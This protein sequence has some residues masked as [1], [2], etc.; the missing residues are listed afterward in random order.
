M[1]IG[2]ALALRLV[3]F[4]ATLA[5][6][7][8][9]LR[10][11]AT[12]RPLVQRH[13]WRPFVSGALLLAAWTA[14]S[15]LESGFGHLFAPGHSL[16][17]VMDGLHAA[18]MTLFAVGFASLLRLPRLDQPTETVVATPSTPEPEPAPAP[19]PELELELAG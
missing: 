17:L 7:L 5:T 14:G 9:A 12:D 3:S 1:S 11:L 2:W 10:L 13:A 8:L 18:G 16:P 6:A 4:V 19:Q 15:F